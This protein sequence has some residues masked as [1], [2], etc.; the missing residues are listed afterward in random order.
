[1]E[2]KTNET[3]TLP[4]KD[5]TLGKLLLLGVMSV[6]LSFVPIVTFLAPLPLI[7]GV[8]LYGRKLAYGLTAL[9]LF[10]FSL[11][12]SI[13]FETG[14]S[15]FVLFAVTSFIVVTVAESILSKI[16]PKRALVMF[17]VISGLALVVLGFGAVKVAEVN[18]AESVQAGITQW[19]EANKED[20]QQMQPAARAELENAFS[21]SGEVA[22]QIVTYLPSF[23]FI[24]Y[25]VV[26]WISFSLVLKNKL[27]WTDKHDYPYGLNDLMN[28]KTPEWVIYP[29]L[30]ALAVLVL[31][32]LKVKEIEAVTSYGINTLICMSLLYFF[33]GFGLLLKLL[34]SLRIF[35]FLRTLFVIST[36]W[37]GKEVIILFG[38][39]D[40]WFDFDKKL[41]KKKV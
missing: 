41:T 12:M 23:A 6:I 4:T 31:D 34:N 3:F 10:G 18:I 7:V 19:Y 9:I 1:M 40:L 20:F 13:S 37:V 11:G 39:L 16:H 32:Q 38:V 28:F 17:G 26:F 14:L 8:L 22:N 29:F 21:R 27:V 2:N 5:L 30:L 15:F 36:V 33:Q 35:G 24:S 25:L